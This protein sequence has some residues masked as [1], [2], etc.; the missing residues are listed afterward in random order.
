MASRVR[1]RGAVVRRSAVFVVAVAHTVEEFELGRSELGDGLYAPIKRIVLDPMAR[2]RRYG[3]PGP[4]A[5][6]PS[7]E[8]LG[9]QDC[10]HWHQRSH[11]HRRDHLSKFEHP[12]SP[13]FMSVTC[14]RS[15]QLVTKMAGKGL[16]IN[17]S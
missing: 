13:S 9:H 6:P 5:V 16:P 1:V 2:I 8:Q 17:V 7:V 14:A 10:R 4:G 11:R 15:D 12:E 3:L